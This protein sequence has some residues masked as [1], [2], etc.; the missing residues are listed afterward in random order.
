MH[1]QNHLVAQIER[2]PECEQVF[3]LLAIVVAIRT[4][5]VQ[6]VR[7]A[8]ADH[9]GGDQTP[10]PLDVRH[11]VAPQVRRGGVTVREDD[12]VA[13]PLVDVRHT[14]AL[15]LAMCSVPYGSAPATDNS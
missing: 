10:Q 11:D 4:R 13:F 7:G 3:A 5:G 6:L 9:V 8:H 12:R 2:I 15:D 1:D 14:A